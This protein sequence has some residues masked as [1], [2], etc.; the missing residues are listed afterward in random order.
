MKHITRTMAL[1]LAIAMLSVSAFAAA[2]SVEQGGAP[3]VVTPGA[4]KPGAPEGK[5]AIEVVD[6]KGEVIATD[7]PN[8][9][10][11][12]P[13]DKL[14]TAD[15]AVKDV[16]EKAYKQLA[17]AED[18]TTVV[19]ELAKAAEDLKMKTPADKLAVRDLIYLALTDK[20][21]AELVKDNTLCFL[22]FDMTLAEGEQLIV[23]VQNPAGEWVLVP[24]ANVEINEAGHPV[25]GFEFFGPTAF[26]V[27]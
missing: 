7:D 17:D 11:V 12:V 27:G 22:E 3:S 16:M 18:L 1:V 26:I 23:M 5:P 14:D 19:P 24:A 2:P 25:V 6:D 15:K 20:L 13:M 8:A 9:L 4:V 10:I 21:N